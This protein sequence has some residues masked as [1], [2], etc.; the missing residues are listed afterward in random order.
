MRREKGFGG[1]TPFCHLSYSVVNL[2]L[3]KAAYVPHLKQAPKAGSS[4]RVPASKY[5]H[6]YLYAHTTTLNKGIL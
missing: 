4:Q 5:K 1:G 6:I 3:I 2:K